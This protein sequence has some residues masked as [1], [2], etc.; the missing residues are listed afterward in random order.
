MEV[1]LWSCRGFILCRALFIFWIKCLD[2]LLVTVY[3]F[4]RR[5]LSFPQS[6]KVF[7]FIT[8]F[9]G[10]NSQCTRTGRAFIYINC[11]PQVAFF[12]SLRRTKGAIEFERAYLI[13]LRVFRGRSFEAL[14]RRWRSS[15]DCWVSQS[16]NIA[17][18]FIFILHGMIFILK[19]YIS[20]KRKEFY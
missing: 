8:F 13:C 12:S 17:V 18:I 9:V 6:L 3:G 11:V 7:N 14:I 1:G 2:Y 16:I 20:L 10:L 15:I 5:F 19:L 4:K